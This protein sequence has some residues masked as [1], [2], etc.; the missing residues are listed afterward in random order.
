MRFRSKRRLPKMRIIANTNNE[1]VKRQ[2]RIRKRENYNFVLMV[3]YMVLCILIFKYVGMDDSGL[4][5]YLLISM[6]F[7]LLMKRNDED[8]GDPILLD[9][10][11][12]EYNIRNIQYELLCLKLKKVKNKVRK[13]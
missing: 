9:Y 2:K 11:F 1:L 4:C 8:M 10:T 3:I 5:M 6:I 13:I 12:S 7:T